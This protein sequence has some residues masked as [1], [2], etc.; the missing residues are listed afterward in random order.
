[1]TQPSSKGYVGTLAHM[2]GMKAAVPHALAL[3]HVTW[4]GE[5]VAGVVAASRA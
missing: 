1:M 3:E 2:T 4:Q 5:P